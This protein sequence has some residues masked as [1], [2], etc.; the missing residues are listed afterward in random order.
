MRS[1][2]PLPS[3]HSTGAR[4]R[5]NL[6]AGA[7][8]ALL[9][10]LASPPPAVARTPDASDARIDRG[11]T[12][13]APAFGAVGDE[14]SLVLEWSGCE[15]AREYV[16][17]LS[18]EPLGGRTVE[19]L[20]ADRTV[21]KHTTRATALPLQVLVRGPAGRT[22]YHWTVAARDPVSGRA[23]RGPD[24][25][26]TAE[27][28]FE[29]ARAEAPLIKA[30][31]RGT[32]P[33]RPAPARLDIRL[34]GGR[35]F[36]P[37]LDGEPR[38]ESRLK[39][40]PAAATRNG[41][42]IVQLRHEV[43]AGER[44][45]LAAAGA[46][47]IAYLPDDAFLIRMTGA[48][49]AAIG[50]LPFVRWV[51]PWH[52]GYKLSSAPAMEQS[53]GSRAL[54]VLLFPDADLAEARHQIEALGGT[55]TEATDSGR[56]KVLRLTL[57]TSRLADL[58]ALDAVAWIEPW[59]DR[60]ANNV[61]AQWVVQTNV[62]NSR[63]V[64]DKGLHGEGQVLHTSDSGVRTSHN[65]FRDGGIP[66]TGFGDYPSHRKIIAYKPTPSAAPFG[67]DA[68][69]SYHGTHTAGTVLGD[70]SPF[71]AD[72]RDGQALK[73]RL[74][75][76]DIGAFGDTV[77]APADLTIL[78][79]EAY[80][81]NAGGG[82]RISSNSWGS[83]LNQYDI[84]SMT[85]DQFMW[86]HK[87]FL[88]CFSN[89]NQAGPGTVG[90]P[91]TNKNG[92]GVG[93]TQNGANAGIKAS[94]SSEGP[95]TDGRRKPTLLAPGDGSLP[96][97]GISSADGGGDT[98]Y[99]ALAGTSM[100]SPA[101]AGA[102][103][104]IRQYFTEGWY[105]SGT[106]TPAHALVPSAALL[107]AM[108]IT[109]TDNDMTAQNIPNTAVGWGRI[110]LD[111]ILFFPG[112]A[113]RTAV[114]DEGD[115]LATGEFAEYEVAVTDASQPL[116]ITLCWTDREGSPGAAIELVNNLDLT[117]TD[118]GNQ[119]YLGN[120]FAGG[121]S[122]LGGAPDLLNV[123]EGV[124]LNAPAAGTWRIRVSGTNVPFGPQPYALVV[125]G[126]VAG[127]S[128]VV[129]L[130]RLRYGRD[131]LMEVRVED[132]NA[133]PPVTAS[134][135]SDSE[136]APEVV[137]L[138]G[139]AGVFTAVVPT[140]AFTA[141]TGDGKLSVSNGDA[142][143]L[144]YTDANPAGATSAAAVAD[145]DGPIISDVRAL[146]DGAAHAITWTSDLMAS[147]RVDYGTTPALGQTSGLDPTLVTSHRLTLTGLIPETEYLFDVESRDHAGN[148]TRDDNA[149][150]HHRFT[151]GKRGEI[152]VVIGDGTF[153][154]DSM[155]VQALAQ[156]GWLPALLRGGVIAQ[157]PLGNRDAGMRSYRAVWWQP[158]LEQYPPFEDAARES[159]A[160]YVNG[161]GR[162]GVSGHDIAWALGDLTSG[163]SNAA[164][165]AWVEGT[166]HER[167]L[168]DPVSCCVNLQGVMGDPVSGSYIAGVPYAP[169][170]Q[171]AAVD[172]VE[173]VAGTGSGAYLWTDTDATPDNCAVRWESGVPNGNPA[174]AVW[175]G[176]PSRTLVDNFEWSGILDA[177][178]RADVLDRSLIW[179]IGN[180]HP[181]ATVTSPNG[182]ETIATSTASIAWTET[183]YGTTS[184]A[185]R[186]LWYSADGGSSWHLISSSP[187]SSPYAWDV[188]ALTNGTHYRVRVS[189]TD[190]GSP[191]LSGQDASDADITLA[192]PGGDAAGPRVLAGS[193]RTS[194]N[195]M[196]NRGTATLTATVTDSPSGESNVVAAEYSWGSSPA[197][198]GSGR[199]MSGAFTS[200]TVAASASV[201]A[202]AVPTGEEQFWVR[203]R[204]AAGNWGAAGA[205]T[206]VV[207]GD[208]TV[209]VEPAA[210]FQ[211]A[212]E[213]SA[214]NPFASTTRIGFSLARAAAVHLG[215]YGVGGERVRTLLD[216][217][218]AAG[219][220]AV[221][222]DGRDDA[223]RVVR[224]GVYF[225][226]LAA[227]ADRATRKMVLMR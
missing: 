114:V 151:T 90:S 171:G 17:F 39:G 28:R 165:K 226:R 79:G 202:L 189:V 10:V 94:F 63:R 187:G 223:G 67:D 30:T 26:F 8:A 160:A 212:L 9:V 51:G 24:A 128:G 20:L 184:I 95:T 183:P 113:K 106:P 60:F 172:E 112:D 139:T 6:L 72:L 124:R 135:T 207:N 127:P 5:S 74:Y 161:G 22:D 126:G 118:P 96:L 224:S 66:I 209:A 218:Q 98:G 32:L 208:A 84:Q 219:P 104:L 37:L 109:S 157:P 216:G 58:A 81:G 52:P 45:R 33:E 217:P 71:A 91:A 83:L 50:A 47:I 80:A 85:V 170:R 53:T 19:A 116:K 107:K 179:L 167:F 227:G 48:T 152:L 77:Y 215:V 11:L 55:M 131:D 88:V 97:S 159:L 41:S 182:G 121:Q 87:D 143:H 101:T 175:G 222:W 69:A 93:A 7:A 166:L 197:P 120:F 155:Y 68:G 73:A 15:W 108:A 190:N 117:V 40:G 4:H 146:D 12:L 49:R 23:T 138:A 145:F 180:D 153:G 176:L 220:H 25:R 137:T 196:D 42:Y 205:A 203:G 31:G 35:R 89:G 115:G 140:T 34:Q 163:F 122:V 62:T 105:P 150:Q 204:D 110:K 100:A 132:L 111:N 174:D 78:F 186:A 14:A 225:Y 185:G 27:K 54:A 141:V 119:A 61:T 76:H 1:I 142:I 181:D 86:E 144:T 38:L 36:D 192:R 21:T 134:L 195:P 18:R 173:I 102:A 2:A 221:I 147:S 149:G 125:S 123:E 46:S 43:K 201:P 57:D 133:V 162:L 56:N 70:D 168:E 191:S 103:A 75:F 213:R 198:A 82:A 3:P 13:L 99:Q 59:A 193:I 148:I 211:F 130:D 156:R 177:T 158:G 199:P 178:T 169:H 136:S 164:R 16:V 154:R 65:A 214:P 92:I 44:E 210:A 194:P 188:S 64:W 206:I 200:A 29:G 129:Q